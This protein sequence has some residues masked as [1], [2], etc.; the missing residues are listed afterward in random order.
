M[1]EPDKSGPNVRCWK[2]E[3]SPEELKDHPATLATW[4]IDAPLAHPAWRWHCIY[5]VHLRELPGQQA[6]TLKTPESTHEVGVFAL[7]DIDDTAYVP[8]LD[9]VKSW[10]FLTPPDAVVQVENLDDKQ[11]LDMLEVVI[12]SVAK[13]ELVPDSD[14][15]RLWEQALSQVAAHMRGEHNH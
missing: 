1:R 7:A 6:A 4:L 8:D 11:A 14:H 13:G 12:A 15:R 2:Y 9:D 3:H 5:L 10:K